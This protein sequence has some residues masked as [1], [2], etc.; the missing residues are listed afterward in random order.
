MGAAGFVRFSLTVNLPAHLL[1]E[2]TSGVGNQ[3]L[4][5]VSSREAF[6]GASHLD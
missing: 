3:G 1:R 2:T 5:V 6:E 4:D